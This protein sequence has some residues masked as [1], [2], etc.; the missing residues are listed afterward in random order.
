VFDILLLPILKSI[1][2]PKRTMMRIDMFEKSA[3]SFGYGRYVRVM[4]VISQIILFLTGIYYFI[5]TQ[6]IIFLG[7]LGISMVL[8]FSY[9]RNYYF[10]YGIFGLVTAEL[11]IDLYSVN[12]FLDKNGIVSIIRWSIAPSLW[13]FAMFYMISGIIHI[14]KFHSVLSIKINKRTERSGTKKISA[15]S[16]YS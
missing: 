4:L 10:I 14:D 15:I 3:N 13:I 6:N 5:A 12:L 16:G 9:I 7:I 1:Y 2:Y 8:V 11:I